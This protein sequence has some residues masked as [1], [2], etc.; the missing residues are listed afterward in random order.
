MGIEDLGDREGWRVDGIAA[1]VH[2]RGESDRFSV[3]YYAPS[4]C[5]LYWRVNENG[6][7]A[8]PVSRGAVPEPLRTRIRTD[9]E[10]AD[11]DPAIEDRR[12]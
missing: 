7:T 3:E 1:R 6:E 8:V 9:L 12:V 2:Y 5:V 4:E 10:A 11:L